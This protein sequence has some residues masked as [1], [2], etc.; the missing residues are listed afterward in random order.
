MINAANRNSVPYRGLAVSRRRAWLLGTASALVLAVTA[1]ARAIVYPPYPEA[2]ND[3][4]N[5]PTVTGYTT[6][7][8]NPVN[9][10]PL[11]LSASVIDGVIGTSTSGGGTPTATATITAN[12]IT[13]AV[14]GNQLTNTLSMTVL[15]LPNAPAPSP[16][17]V[18]MLGESDNTGLVAT[19]LIANNYLA[20]QLTASA[21]TSATVS[22]N[23]MSA[24]TTL[25]NATTTLQG[26]VPV[27][28]TAPAYDP[29]YGS[30]AYSTTNSPPYYYQSIGSVLDTNV[31]QNTTSG[32]LA[33]SGAMVTES[34]LG[35]EITG[36]AEVADTLSGSPAVTDNSLTAAFTGNNAANA[37]TLQAGDAPTFYGSAT[38]TN[39]QFNGYDSGTS[40]N[41]SAIVKYSY[42]GMIV[43]PGSDG[44]I[45]LTGAASVTG[46]AITATAIG[47]EAAGLSGSNPTGNI[48]TLSGGIGLSG[49]GTSQQSDSY[50]VGGE[51]GTYVTGD[52]LVNNTQVNYEAP[53]DSE[54]KDAAAL[55]VIEAVT[56]GSVAVSDN[57]IAAK[58]IG[59]E[60]YNALLAPGLG[61]DA[62]GAPI[63]GTLASNSLQVN[64][65]SP[66]TATVELA[67][68]AIGTGPATG[69]SLTANGNTVTASATGN[70]VA[71]SVDLNTT[72]L[73]SY[74]GVGA[75]AYGERNP[76]VY[77]SQTYTDD[78]ESYADVMLTSLQQNDAASPVTATNELGLVGIAAGVGSGINDST[79]TVTGTATAALAE[80]NAASNALVLTAANVST[81]AALTAAQS[82]YGTVTATL[83]DAVTGVVAGAGAETD[84]IMTLNG[85]LERAIATGNDA[86]S[87]VSVS[88][89]I[90]TVANSGGPASVFY[91]TPGQAFPVS[92]D[93][94]GDDELF[95]GFI[96]YN[97]Q[98]TTASITATVEST[99]P[100]MLLG[101]NGALVGTSADNSANAIAAAAR[102]ND[103]TTQLTLAPTG[104][105]SLYNGNN[106]NPLDTTYSPFAVVANVQQLTDG[107]NVGAV[108]TGGV[109]P[110]IFTDILTG[111]LSGATVTMT[112]N[113]FQAL[114]EGDDATNALTLS[115]A[116]TVTEPALS[117]PANLIVLPYAN[118]SPP[119]TTVTADNAFV[120]HNLQYAGDGTI[121][122]AQD[123]TGVEAAITGVVSD[124]SVQVGGV[125][126]PLGNIVA[127]TAAANTAANTLT[128]NAANL[129]ASA[130]LLN[131]QVGN[132]GV[133]ATL[134]EPGTV[135]SPDTPA[136][137]GTPSFV[138]ALDGNV[139]DSVL[140]VSSN[141]VT[142]ASTANAATNT[143]SSTAAISSSSLAFTNMPIQTFTGPGAFTDPT[144][145]A[146]VFADIGLFNDQ[147]IGG[148]GVSTATANGSFGISN[149]AAT[150]TYTGSTL[151]INGNT[152]QANAL[153]NEA[154][155]SLTLSPG[156]TVT[157]APPQTAA[158]LSLQTVDSAAGTPVTASS[159]MLVTAPLALSGS[160]LAISGNR[161]T[162]SAIANDVTNSLSVDGTASLP[163][164]NPAQIGYAQALYEQPSMYAYADYA[165]INGQI[166][167][168]GSVQ[169]TATTTI[170]NSDL[171]ADPSAIS[172]TSV[173][174]DGN[175]TLAQALAN[176]ASN[177]LTIT[178]PGTSGVEG[179][180]VNNQNSAAS[181]TAT[182]TIEMVLGLG[183]SPAATIGSASTNATYAVTNNTTQAL[184]TGNQ[185][186]N[187]LN[188]SAGA[189]GST[190]ITPGSNVNTGG[191][192]QTSATFTVLNTQNNTASVTA[193][194][195]GTSPPLLLDGIISTG[196]G[197]GGY[198]VALNTASGAGNVVNVSGNTVTSQAI[199]NRA[200]NALTLVALNVGAASASI[201]SVQHN[202]AS[203]TA[204]V[205]N[206]T[207]GYATT[208][209][210]VGRVGNNQLAAA[211]YGNVV[212]NAITSR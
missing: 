42:L 70:S 121:T 203:I 20:Q 78:F 96:A 183:Q 142:A 45:A 48:L 147:A 194:V 91:V 94:V 180:V 38:L 75:S 50:L 123:G 113:Q 134:G 184:A 124:S 208:Q 89:P 88:A 83:I 7:L 44:T 35:E 150:P 139:T 153:G 173:T 149:A 22:D 73:Q 201:N 47:N 129:S 62:S 54:V 111:G 39:A 21:A 168:G 87:T 27:N 68:S 14:G 178:T 127:S 206:V 126:A 15:P 29:T 93:L 16:D 210:T 165:L 138:I 137:F 17:G 156:L 55:A 24:A 52:V 119:Y 64:M 176:R 18:T 97:D 105:L 205:N 182:A 190:G 118:A 56:G 79:L 162:T 195:Y 5:G 28:Y 23:I 186:S 197:Q 37:L 140:A 67:G 143:V 193:A 110:S 31:Q 141:Q 161:N 196:S 179:A 72:S 167:T 40:G 131:Y 207:V 171:Y 80:G 174:V 198:G 144:Y 115:N 191:N 1:P 166:V 60:A 36:V 81:S 133:G 160:T 61:S 101:T 116:G 59:N 132:S 65:S 154:T 32:E 114:A 185:A 63:V 189:Y 106:A 175:A 90:V 107:T 151:T 77:D 159:N 130:G 192:P 3:V 188:V 157:A 152:Q 98:A 53:L 172:N 204:S 202:S 34:Y 76:F 163:G 10:G 19:S 120:V 12:S 84:S 13:A 66:V 136:A 181:V 4:T 170:V 46:N 187:A 2:Y 26:Q 74:N 128:L 57:A 211:A 125:T 164:I 109:A 155:N 41:P 9:I 25:N 58:S 49:I 71:N 85:N 103:A 104:S 199:G 43:L 122:A 146:V 82:S 95:A 135:P 200:D 8:L 169:S 86:A 92:S 33:G 145:G 69:A 99:I 212:T 112:A 30:S 177:T 102:G 209:G 11:T 100:G 108:M 117:Q 51:P 6:S 158:L 148:D